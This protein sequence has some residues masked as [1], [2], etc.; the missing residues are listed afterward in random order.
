MLLVMD[1]NEAEASF[2]RLLST[3]FREGK[4]RERGGEKKNSAISER[5]ILVL[6]ATEH[7][8]GVGIYG[9]REVLRS[10]W[11]GEGR[12]A[13]QLRVDVQSPEPVHQRERGVSG[14]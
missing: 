13:V 2:T 9:L 14:T 7:A 3:S 10:R 1:L 12:R 6:V 11:G 5:K 4:E 8:D